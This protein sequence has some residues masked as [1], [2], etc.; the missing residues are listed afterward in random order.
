MENA[1][2]RARELIEDGCQM[3]DIGGESTRPGSEYVQIQEE[4]SR[5]VPVIKAIREISDIPISVDTWKAEVAEAALIAGAD[6]INDITGFIGDSKMADVVG[7]HKAG[8]ILMFNP[9][10]AR[11]N[12]IN[13]KKF[14]SFGGQGVFSDEEINQMENMPIQ[15]A[16]VYYL[17]KSINIAHGS[18]IEDN[19]LMLDP[20]IGFG[21]TR[22]E[23]LELFE[24]SSLI[25]EMGYLSFVGVSRKRFIVSLLEENNHTQS[26]DTLNEKDMA[27]SILTGIAAYKGYNILRVHTAEFHHFGKIIGDAVRLNKSME[28]VELKRYEKN[29]NH[30]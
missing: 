1:V 6:I 26:E 16:M 27:S 2:E 9:V 28:D 21:L 10:I 11:P 22:N 20:G 4:I 24:M 18:G 13:S 23:N 3:L 25:N 12:N 17:R 30:K 15:E 19:K 29:N 5:V 7:K 14:P 8:A